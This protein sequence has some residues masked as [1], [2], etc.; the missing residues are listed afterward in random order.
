MPTANEWRFDDAGPVWSGLQGPVDLASR[1]MGLPA[2][3]GLYVVTCGDCLAHVGTS[4]GLRGRVSSLARLGTHRGSAEV[5]CAAFCSEAAPLVWWEELTDVP[6]ARGREREF[7][8]FYGEPPSPRSKYADCVNGGRL[9]K[10]LVE[11]AGRDSWEAGFIDAV[12]QIGE[13]L[14]LLFGPRFEESWSKV[15]KPPGPWGV[16]R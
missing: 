11:A 8:L 15:G 5:L 12:F 4:G 1:A 7:K 14:S 10:A 13:K 3:P 16:S 9:M 6:T 2:R